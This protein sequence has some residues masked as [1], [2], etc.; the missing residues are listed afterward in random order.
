MDKKIKKVSSAHLFIL[1]KKNQHL[2]SSVASSTA[3]AATASTF[4]R[5]SVEG[6]SVLAGIICFIRMYGKRKGY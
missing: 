6:K 1:K 2:N 3:S 4:A 5:L